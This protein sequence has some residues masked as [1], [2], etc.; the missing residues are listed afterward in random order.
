VPCLCIDLT[1][2]YAV[3]CYLSEAAS[4]WLSTQ[5][6]AQPMPHHSLHPSAPWLTCSHFCTHSGI[7]NQHMYVLC[8]DRGFVCQ[9][10]KSSLAVIIS[11]LLQS[12]QCPLSVCCAAPPPPLSAFC[13]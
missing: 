8:V 4:S 13:C 6:R 3:F 11:L 2:I 10:C 7:I 12:T 9:S 5:L 1:F